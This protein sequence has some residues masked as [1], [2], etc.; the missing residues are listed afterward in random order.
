M[1]T[2]CQKASLRFGVSGLLVASLLAGCAEPT[3]KA[4]AADPGARPLPQGATCQSLRTE[5]KVLD[6]R[7]VQPHVE[8]LQAGKKLPDAQKVEAERYNQLLNQYLGARCHV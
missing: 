5:L 1:P 8:A 4:N 7:G 2:S 6:G 3:Y